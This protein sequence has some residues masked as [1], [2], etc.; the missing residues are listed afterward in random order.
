MMLLGCLR[1]MATEHRPFEYRQNRICGVHAVFEALSSEQQPIE[2]IHISRDAHSGKIR[3][4]VEIAEKRE[5]L[6]ARVVRGEQRREGG[7]DDEDDDE[8]EAG[9]RS[10]V[11]PKAVPRIGPEPA[12]SSRPVT[13]IDRDLVDRAWV[14]GRRRDGEARSRRVGVGAGRLAGQTPR[15]LYRR[16]RRRR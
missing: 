9:D 7:D 4:I 3:E 6:V 14:G 1:F 15:A 16:S 5:I 8:D 11:A 12:R 2:R 13:G 10:W